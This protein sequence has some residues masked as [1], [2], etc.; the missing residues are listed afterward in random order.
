MADGKNK[1]S[2]ARGASRGTYN[3]TQVV[4]RAGKTTL[5]G[6]AR[7]G[8]REPGSSPANVRRGS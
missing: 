6:A 1:S 8:A 3:G 7:G 5:A 4:A 2:V